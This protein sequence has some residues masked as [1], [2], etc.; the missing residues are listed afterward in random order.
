MGYKCIVNDLTGSVCEIIN[1]N[2]KSDKIRE[3]LAKTTIKYLPASEEHIKTLIERAKQSPKPL[4]FN[5]EFFEKTVED[6]KRSKNIKSD[7]DIIP[8]EFCIYSFPLLLKYRMPK[9]EK[10]AE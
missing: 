7:E 5:E 4:L 6:F 10:I 1:F 9:Y 8:D 3:F 2:D